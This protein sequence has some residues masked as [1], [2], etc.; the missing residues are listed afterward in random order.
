M[1][2]MD[3]IAPIP[4]NTMQ[5][6]HNCEMVFSFFYENSENGFRVTVDDQKYLIYTT[7]KEVELFNETLYLFQTP[8]FKE[9]FFNYVN[10][11]NPETVLSGFTPY[12]EHAQRLS[13][14]LYR[15]ANDENALTKLN[16]HCLQIPPTYKD[17][18]MLNK[19]IDSLRV[20]IT[21]KEFNGYEEVRSFLQEQKVRLGHL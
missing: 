10:T 6:Y 18:F 12:Y 11:M 8:G 15:A 21:K 4:V 13:K 19:Q 1:G 9:D 3:L 5:A 7:L 17:D 14:S 16:D 20:G 2:L